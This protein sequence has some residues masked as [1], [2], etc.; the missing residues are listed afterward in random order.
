MNNSFL[1]FGTARDI[2]AFEEVVWR[3]AWAVDAS[4]KDNDNQNIS[5][6]IS[7][8]GGITT[9]VQAGSGTNVTEAA[10]DKDKDKDEDEDKD[11]DKDEEADREN[12]IVESWFLF[13][14]LYL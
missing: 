10:K 7:F 3:Y 12:Y 14:G 6:P 8:P 4:E 13:V 9:T 2:S 1:S 5:E 11:K